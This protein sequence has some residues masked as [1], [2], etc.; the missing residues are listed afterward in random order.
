VSSLDNMARIKSLDRGDMYGAIAGFPDQIRQAVE[1]FERSEIDF[2]SLGDPDN[3][4]LCGMGGSAIGGELVRSLL[5]DTL[6]VPMHI[7]RNYR[8][9]GFVNENTLVI[10][11]SYSGT[12][13]ETLAAVEEAGG[14]GCRM[15]AL[16]TGG[17]LGE[18]FDRLGLP[19]IDLPAGYQPRA[20]LG[21]SFVPLMLLFQKLGLSAYGPDHF[22][23]L[24]DFL[25]ERVFELALQVPSD[26]NAA[27]QLAMQLYGRLTIIYSGPEMTGAGAIRFKGQICENAKTLA[28]VNHFPE[29]NHN[30]LVGWKVIKAFRDYLRVIVIRDAEDNP[31]VAARMD[32]VRQ[33][34]E[35]EGVRVIEVE[36][37]GSNRLERLMSMVQFGDMVSFYLAI[38]NQ[39]DP[40]PVAPIDFLKEELAKLK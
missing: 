16:T 11:S 22:N 27:K 26:D 9:P 29:F 8:L 20:A 5:Y 19:R 28:F 2:E 39:V 25:D 17:T 30:E 7:C 40:T 31:G 37:L 4:V 21:F 23:D 18:K 24:A 13:E 36:T 38:L 1:T 34:I 14:K 12:T 33:M 6:P 32:I 10:A 35:K 3:I 15:L